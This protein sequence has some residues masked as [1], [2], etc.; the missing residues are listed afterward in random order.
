MS[1]LFKYKGLN[2]I[3]YVFL[4]IYND[5]KINDLKLDLMLDKVN[6]KLL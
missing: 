1:W 6:K 5:I 4:I 2:I 3:I